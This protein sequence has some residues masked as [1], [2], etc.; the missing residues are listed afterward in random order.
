MPRTPHCLI[1]RLLAVLVLSLTASWSLPA[2]AQDVLNLDVGDPAR[3]DKTVAL[4]LDGIVDTH[5]GAVL[6]PDETAARLRDVDILFVGESHT[7]IDFHR[8]QELIIKALLRQGREVLIGL[9]MFPVTEQPSLDRWIDDKPTEEQFV[10]FSHWYKNWG[11]HWNYYREIFL[12]AQKAGAR[13]FALNAP[14]DVVTAV[15]RKGIDNLSPEEAA[16]LPPSI[17]TD[18]ADHL[19]LFKSYFSDDDTM[20][21]GMTDEQWRSMFAAQCTWDAT[22]GYNAVRAFQEHG[23][24]KAIVVVLIGSGHVSYGLGIERQARRFFEGRTATMIPVPVRESDGQPVDTVRA[25]YADFVWGVPGESDSLYPS[26]GISTREPDDGRGL[27]VLMVQ[28]DSPG[29]RA[30]I[31][32][33]DLLLS[34]DDV[35]LDNKETFNRLVAGKRWSDAVQLGYE[36]DG[37]PA[38]V[39]FALRRSR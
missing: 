25:S 18:N 23:A 6:T 22:M 35:A 39:T 14:R 5:D 17:D 24:D 28:D 26:L 7:S 8:A 2:Q 20:H 10:A 21:A 27:S 11:Y 3:R 38:T 19:R 32:A 33:G 13:M 37:Q 30:G 16:Y 36:R 9:E 15:R 12:T 34:V 1:F 31:K 4:L 29:G